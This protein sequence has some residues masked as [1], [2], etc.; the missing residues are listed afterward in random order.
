MEAVTVNDSF[1]LRC[2]EIPIVHQSEI[3]LSL[4][5]YAMMM[6]NIPSLP[7]PTQKMPNGEMPLSQAAAFAE[8]FRG[9]WRYMWPGPDLKALL[10]KRFMQER[11]NP[12]TW[13]PITI[14]DT[15]DIP[16]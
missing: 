13:Y 5:R 8:K 11:R 2:G 1:S 16:V 6:A 4:D 3:I 14:V 7:E 12:N 10:I 9:K 15:S